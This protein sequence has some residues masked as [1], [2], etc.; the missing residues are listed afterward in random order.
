VHILHL[1]T[2]R[3]LRGGQR[4]L[5]LLARGLAARGHTQVVLARRHGALLVEAAGCALEMLPLGP[6][7]LAEEA[8][9]A[10]LIHAHDARAHTL[11]ALLVR[12]LPLV[13]SRRVAFP[14]GAGPL[15]RWKYAR[16]TRFLAVSEFVRSRLVEAGV[17]RE[18]I[19]VVYDGVALPV[20]NDSAPRRRVV[21]AP[22]TDDPQKGSRLAEEACRAAGVELKFSSRLEDDLPGAGLFLYLSYCEGLGSGILLAMAHGAPVVAS[23]LGGIP[24]IVEHGRTGLLVENSSPAVAAA[25]RVVLADPSAAAQ[26][27]EAACRQVLE[28]FT[29]AIMVSQTERAYQLALSSQPSTLSQS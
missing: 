26:R 7:T 3:E 19:S 29:D 4:Q 27:A 5:L 21:V 20:R 1:D 22:A 6:A 2:G 28:R 8:R 23:R 18:R 10:D 15:S 24:E 9:R 11:A 17:G 12:R 14:I 16:A 13:V 25:I